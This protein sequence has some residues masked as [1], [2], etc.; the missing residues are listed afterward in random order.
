MVLGIWIPSVVGGILK[1]NGMISGTS[2]KK[3]MG[4]SSELCKIHVC[5]MFLISGLD[6]VMYEVE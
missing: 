5:F 4:L 3:W 1:C 2:G 6:I